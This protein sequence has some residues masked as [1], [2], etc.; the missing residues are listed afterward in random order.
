MLLA[1]LLVVDFLEGS[2]NNGVLWH[3]GVQLTFFIT[4]LYIGPSRY[5]S[6]CY[7]TVSTLKFYRTGLF[8]FY[9]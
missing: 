3:G 6:P 2:S 4:T 5:K 8:P 1:L 9:D 7:L